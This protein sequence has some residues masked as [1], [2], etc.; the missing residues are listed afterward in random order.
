MTKSAGLAII[1]M[2][3]ACDGGSPADTYSVGG[4]ATGLTSGSAVVLQLNG[5][6]T[7]TISADGSF[8]VGPSLPDH[9]GY[10]ATVLTQPADQ[11]CNLGYLYARAG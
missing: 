7:T 10:S 2:L 4:T 11:F 3:A 8:T 6:A 1:A 9:V 5:F